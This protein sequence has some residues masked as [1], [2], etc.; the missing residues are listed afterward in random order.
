MAV[1]RRLKKQVKECTSDHQII[2]GDEFIKALTSVLVREMI[3]QRGVEKL[4]ILGETED[5][6]DFLEHMSDYK[7]PI[8]LQSFNPARYEVFTYRL[9]YDKGCA[10]CTSYINPDNWEKG[11]LVIIFDRNLQRF[12]MGIPGVFCV[13]LI[14]ESKDLAPELEHMLIANGLEPNLYNLAPLLETCLK[15]WSNWEQNKSSCRTG[16]NFVYYRELG[17]HIGLWDLFL[18]NAL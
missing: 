7:I 5:F 1:D 14:D 3:S 18:D 13:R 16:K 11:D 12:S 9:L 10:I 15:A 2:Y 17:D 8:S 4:I 6:A